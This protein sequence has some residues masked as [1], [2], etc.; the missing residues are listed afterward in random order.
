[1]AETVRWKKGVL[2]ARSMKSYMY[3]YL[4]ARLFICILSAILIISREK[5][6]HFS[7]HKLSWDYTPPHP[8]PHQFSIC[9]TIHMAGVCNAVPY[10]LCLLTL[11]TVLYI[12]CV[13]P[14]SYDNFPCQDVWSACSV[15]VRPT[16]GC[17]F[18]GEVCIFSIS[19]TCTI[20]III[21]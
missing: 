20:S 21:I 7:P 14:P 5:K 13:G 18:S 17:C 16:M 1:M 15:T 6:I 19:C 3:T 2:G 12:G 10:G 11:N 9:V 4:F 8:H